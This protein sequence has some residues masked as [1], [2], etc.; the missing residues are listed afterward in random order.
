MNL[1][2]HA[3]KKNS[4]PNEL[5]DDDLYRNS[6]VSQGEIYEEG[7][8]QTDSPLA[9]YNDVES[10]LFP[11]GGIAVRRCQDTITEIN[12]RLDSDIKSPHRTFISI[13]VLPY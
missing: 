8:Y 11:V 6:E 13:S 4:P 7:F 12:N 1:Q 3:D 9:T 10:G 2:C 5:T